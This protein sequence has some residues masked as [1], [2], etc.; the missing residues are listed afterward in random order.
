MLSIF[1]LF[2]HCQTQIISYNHLLP[3]SQNRYTW[4][5]CR[6]YF[7]CY[8][9]TVSDCHQRSCAM[10]W[11]KMMVCLKSIKR[12]KYKQVGVITNGRKNGTTKQ[13]TENVAATIIQSAYR[14]YKASNQSHT[15]LISRM[16]L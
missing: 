16:L 2:S 11:L 8:R 4:F 1:S 14:A 15:R 13:L 10:G 6:L 12:K 9:K 5:H 7:L 3:P